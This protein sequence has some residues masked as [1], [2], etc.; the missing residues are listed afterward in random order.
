MGYV[1]Q[2]EIDISKVRFVDTISLNNTS[3]KETWSFFPRWCTFSEVPIRPFTKV[4]KGTRRI[5]NQGYRSGYSPT[6][7]TYWALPNELLLYKL[8]KVG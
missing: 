6:V 4:M 5:V 7:Q 2:E 8:T 1:T 3:W